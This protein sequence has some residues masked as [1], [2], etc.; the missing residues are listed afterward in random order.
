[1]IC[2]TSVWMFG[3]HPLHRLNMHS[4]PPAVLCSSSIH[5]RGSGAALRNKS[6][7]HAYTT[8]TDADLDFFRSVVGS[9]HVKTSA[10]ELEG[11]NTDWMKKY[12]GHSPAAVL[13]A[14]TEQVARVLR[15]CNER[16]IAVVPQ[17]GNTGLVGGSVPVARVGEV[18]LSTSRMNAVGSFDPL[19]GVLVCEVLL[20][21]RF[22]LG[23]HR[24]RCLVCCTT[25]YC[26]V[27][28]VRRTKRVSA[29]LSRAFNTD[30][31]GV[32][33]SS[34]SGWCT[35]HREDASPFLRAL[36]VRTALKPLLE[37]CGW[38]DDWALP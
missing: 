24:N 23:Q 18:V 21:A 36:F 35:A 5:A 8:V 9:S 2:T 31:M 3:L 16:D 12:R 38:L 17:G 14:T 34:S 30:S 25:V 22:R 10:E 4:I 32:L 28:A 37:N 1:M 20:Y 6:A 15:H 33:C 19:A 27:G 11:F 29:L 13:P 7:S 26:V